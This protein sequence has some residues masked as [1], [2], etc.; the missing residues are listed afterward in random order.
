[1]PKISFIVPVYKVEPYIDQCVTSILNQTFSDFE[2]ILV[3]D[4]SP[5]RCPEICDTYAQKDSRVK[6]IHKQ[7]AGVSEARNTGIEAASGE[8]A[9][10]VDSD[11]W[12]ELD[13]AEKLY[14][15]AIKTGADCVMSDCEVCFESGKIIR[16]QQFSQV[17]YTEDPEDIR[18]I[19]KNMLCHKFSPHYSAN[20]V[21]GYA[22]PWGKFV[23]LSII[24]DNGIRFDPYAKGVFDDGV[25]SL[26]LLDHVKKFYYNG[27]HTYNYR[28][29]G[30][31]LT[32]A[33]KPTAMDVARRN[34]E[35]V[36]QFIEKTGKDDSYWQAEYCRRVALFA[37]H[38]SKY[39]FN[40]QNPMTKE[41]VCKALIETLNNEN[42]KP[43]FENA[44]AKYLERKHAYVC[45]C[46]KHK[47][48]NGLA[49]YV[50]LKQANDKR[51]NA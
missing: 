42:F 47:L 11:D 40:P 27:E 1:M 32:H 34:C 46:G 26:Y 12:I 29:V 18:N 49:L 38:L 9:Y 17:F 6:V 5:D 16:R 41:E 24:K 3:D 23:K 15:D 8:W 31:S 44:Q 7:N 19:Q 35:L 28:I 2:L 13:A 30:N 21:N 48:Y 20:C 39:F 43:A 33:F 4:G 25:Y 37:S 14:Q 50:K 36:A 10:F 51:Q 22:A 45:F